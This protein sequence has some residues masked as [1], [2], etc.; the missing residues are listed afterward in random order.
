MADALSRLPADCSFTDDDAYVV[1]A[2]FDNLSAFT[3]DEVDKA[4][5]QDQVLIKVRDFI[6]NG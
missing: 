1:I 4:S 5:K 2:F 6:I 3:V